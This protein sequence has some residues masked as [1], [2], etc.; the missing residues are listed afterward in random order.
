[1]NDSRTEAVVFSS[2]SHS[3]HEH[4]QRLLH[5]LQV[6]QPYRVFYLT[7]HAH[8]TIIGFKTVIIG[9]K[10]IEIVFSE[11]TRELKGQNLPIYSAAS[12]K[13]SKI[14]FVRVV[15]DIFFSFEK[16]NC[17]ICDFCHWRKSFRIIF[18]Q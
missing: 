4:W 17:S 8:L 7:L 11:M 15:I 9:S 10:I 6:G 14:L 13:F 16:W 2:L 18:V 5:F 12:K 1:L 3:Q